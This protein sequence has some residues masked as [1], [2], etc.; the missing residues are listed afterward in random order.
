MM[1]RPRVL[2]KWLSLKV[3]FVTLGMAAARTWGMH[4]LSAPLS[5]TTAERMLMVTLRFGHGQAW[6]CAFRLTSGCS[7]SRGR[8]GDGGTA[9]KSP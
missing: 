1:C 8:F 3:M 2:S 5:E 6:D 7:S 9:R 4:A